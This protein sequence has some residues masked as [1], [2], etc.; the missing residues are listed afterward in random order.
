MVARPSAVPKLTVLWLDIA[1]L[2]LTGWLVNIKQ[3]RMISNGCVRSVTTLITI[4]V[5][6]MNTVS[7]NVM[8]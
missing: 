4:C 7:N 3:L 2:I 6:I 1:A 8:E 5:V